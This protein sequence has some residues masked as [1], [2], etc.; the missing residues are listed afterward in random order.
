MAGALSAEWLKFRRTGAWA[1]VVGPPVL[2]VLALLWYSSATD[3]TRQPEWLSWTVLDGWASIFVP[4]GA[5]LLGGLAAHREIGAGNWVALR[6]RPVRPGTLYGAKLLVVLLQALASVVVLVALVLLGTA[7]TGGGGAWQT[8]TAGTGIVLLTT[9]PL[10]LFH[11]WL[12]MAKGLGA[13]LAVGGGGVLVASLLGG[14]SLGNGIWQVVPWAWP[15]RG[16]AGVIA[17]NWDRVTSVA[18]LAGALSLA[19]LAG[20]LYWFGKWEGKAP[21]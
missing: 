17:G 13:S 14:T 10:L 2:L 15:L 12:A 21:D 8:V 9:L 18:G 4:M 11:L 16:A 19:L 5:A 1:V 6:S 3:V 20:T 7:L